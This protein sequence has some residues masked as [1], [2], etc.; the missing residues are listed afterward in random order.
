VAY[1]RDGNTVTIGVQAP[2]ANNWWR[3]FLDGGPITLQLDGVH[4]SGYAVSSRD[5][6]GRVTVTVQL[7]D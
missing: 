1:K 2:D 5:D 7:D 6:R 3:N 4:R